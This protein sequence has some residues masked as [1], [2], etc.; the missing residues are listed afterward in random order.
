MRVGCLDE[1]PQQ[2]CE[3]FSPSSA[4][5]AGEQAFHRG[6]RSHLTFF[7]PAYTICSAN[8]QPCVRASEGVAGAT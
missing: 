5:E 1:T 6:A 8:S 4:T 2:S 3:R 7:L